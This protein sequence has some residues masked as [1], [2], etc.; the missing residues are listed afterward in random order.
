MPTAIMLP[1]AN[2]YWQQHA[3]VVGAASAWQALVS[4][5]SDSSYVVMTATAANPTPN[6]S[7]YFHGSS[8]LK[9]IALRIIATFRET[10]AEA[11]IAMGVSRRSTTRPDVDPPET[12]L[13]NAFAAT[14]S[15]VEQGFPFTV[16]PYTGAA[17]QP[18]AVNGWAALIQVS[19]HPLDVFPVTMRVTALRVEIDY[20]EPTY[21]TV[22]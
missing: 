1:Q 6:L 18:G 21:Y 17:W 20:D 14:S 13:G 8:N 2:G 3:G 15:Y 7:V 9:P 5:D 22:G 19:K 10:T 4:H 12:V 16:H 11:Q